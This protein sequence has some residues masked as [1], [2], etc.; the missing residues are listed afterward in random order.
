MIKCS[1]S[2]LLYNK[3]S[4]QFI[5]TSLGTWKEDCVIETVEI[6]TLLPLINSLF[7]TGPNVATISNQ[8]I[9]NHIIKYD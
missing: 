7:T 4:V 9:N 6:F 2:Q 3:K 1:L 8:T 5:L